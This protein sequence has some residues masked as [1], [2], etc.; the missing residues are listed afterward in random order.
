MLIWPP[1]SSPS[2]TSLKYFKK[3]WSRRE[4]KERRDWNMAALKTCRKTNACSTKYKIR[5]SKN[6]P[7]RSLLYSNWSKMTWMESIKGSLNNSNKTKCLWM[8]G[9]SRSLK[10][11]SMTSKIHQLFLSWK[12]SWSWPI[13]NCI[14]NWGTRESPCA[15]SRQDAWK[16]WTET[17]MHSL[18][19]MMSCTWSTQNVAI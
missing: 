9:P 13:K 8:S 5:W 19:T 11:S 4:W 15:N 17:S 6:R 12:S 10:P 14:A 3:R 7:D 16:N 1:S 2:G 18:T